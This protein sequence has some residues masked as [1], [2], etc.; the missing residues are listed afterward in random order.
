MWRKINDHI[1]LLKHNDQI[2]YTCYVYFYRS[3]EGRWLS[4]GRRKSSFDFRMSHIAT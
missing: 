2:G 1:V 3:R 4:F